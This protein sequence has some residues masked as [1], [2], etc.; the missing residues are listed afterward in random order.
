MSNFAT[1]TERP[2]LS[3]GDLA[4]LFFN[5]GRDFLALHIK[6]TGGMDHPLRQVARS[7]GP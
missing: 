3:V 4:Q 2:N 7:C 6:D 5:F 1:S